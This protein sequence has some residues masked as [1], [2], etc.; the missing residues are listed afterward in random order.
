MMFFYI[1]QNFI[2]FLT[3]IIE[4]NFLSPSHHMTYCTESLHSL[5][6]IMESHFPY[7]NHN[8][9]LYLQTYPI[10][11]VVTYSV[12]IGTHILSYVMSIMGV[13]TNCIEQKIGTH[14]SHDHDLNFVCTN[15]SSRFKQGN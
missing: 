3:S 15:Y 8:Y 2:F 5:I 9:T 14:H 6:L 12:K 13:M 7:T 10:L 4:N 11:C 1:K